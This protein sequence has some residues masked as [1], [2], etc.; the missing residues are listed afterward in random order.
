MV[1]TFKQIQCPSLVLH[2]LS[3]GSFPVADNQTIKWLAEK[4]LVA[5]HGLVLLIELSPDRG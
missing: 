2:T 1:L 5:W 3:V 4:P